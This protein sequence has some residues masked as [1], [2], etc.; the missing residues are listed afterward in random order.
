MVLI[1][2]ILIAVAIGGG[3]L[4][5]VVPDEKSE[6]IGFR[7]SLVF[8]GSY[9]FSITIIHL[10]P[11][12][13]TSGSNTVMI[14]AYILLGFFLQQI[15][16][17]FTA[18]IEHGH[19]HVKSDAHDHRTL[20]AFTVLFA[21]SIHAFMEGTLLSNPINSDQKVNILL[22]GIVFH[23]IPAAFA[24]MSVILCNF[25]DK[26]KAFLLLLVFAFAT[27]G[28]VLIS[29]LGV[30]NQWITHDSLT[31]LFALVS[32]SFLHI[33]TTIVFESSPSHT[34]SIKKLLVG[35]SGALM[36]VGLEYFA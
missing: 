11:D 12:L 15:L 25:H 32:G 34:F 10:I 7:L 18:G 28:G 1:S 36:A 8:A 20:S 33:S 16:E 6:G 5:F 2:L 31:I 29:S 14:G 24:L 22:L 19:M 35:I 17:Y 30:D 27:P 3:L 23:K 4:N 13:Y 26:K 9:L 21:L